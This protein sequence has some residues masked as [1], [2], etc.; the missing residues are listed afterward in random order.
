MMVCLWWIKWNNY[1]NLLIETQWVCTVPSLH[2]S[3]AKSLCF[4][5]K[6]PNTF[7][8]PPIAPDQTN[9]D[10]QFLSLVKV[11][12]ALKLSV[13]MYM[14]IVLYQHQIRK[15]LV[16]QMLMSVVWICIDVYPSM[17]YVSVC[18]H[19]CK[20]MHCVGVHACVHIH[21]LCGCTHLYAHLCIVYMYMQVEFWDPKPPSLN[22]LLHCLMNMGDLTPLSC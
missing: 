12:T 13:I 3:I 1:S 14:P 21:V 16:R 9:Q 15:V 2:V 7:S 5:L 11:T 6:S 22:L 19:V 17:Y 10:S 8:L 4:P 18:M 20:S